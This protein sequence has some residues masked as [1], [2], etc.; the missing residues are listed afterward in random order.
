MAGRPRDSR[1][2]INL[3]VGLAI[4]WRGARW[5]TGFCQSMALLWQSLYINFN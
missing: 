5:Q 3:S 4:F 1:Y 2:A